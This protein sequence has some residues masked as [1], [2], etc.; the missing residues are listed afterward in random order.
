[1][2]SITDAHREEARAHIRDHA[3]GEAARIGRL[4]RIR[5][6]VLGAQDG[7]LVPLGV[8]TGMAAANPGQAAIL[9]AGLAEAVAGAIAMGAGS[10]LASGAEE[11][12]YRAEI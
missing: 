11:A 3:L 1:M 9:V 6:F 10:F 12:F 8:V 2:S 5:E 4:S 7:L